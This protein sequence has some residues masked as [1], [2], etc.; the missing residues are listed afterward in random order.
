MAYQLRGNSLEACTCEEYCPCWSG[1]ENESCGTVLSWHIANGTI[2][3]VD[4]SGR[5]V[6]VVASIPCS[7][8]AKQGAASATLYIDDEATPEQEEALLNA[9]TGRLGGPVADLAQLFGEV[10]GTERAPIS[11]E[12]DGGTGTLAIGQQIEVDMAPLWE[13]EGRAHTIHEDML[14][15]TTSRSTAEEDPRSQEYSAVQVRFR[16]E[17]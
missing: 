5:D 15:S 11:F 14:S 12:V 9:W 1:Y 17:A 16:F 13:A 10:T 3:G 7:S 2:E 4:V 8:A 6:A